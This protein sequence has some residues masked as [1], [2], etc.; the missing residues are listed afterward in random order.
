VDGLGDIRR[1]YLTGDYANGM[2]TGVIGLLFVGNSIDGGYLAN[3]VKK[4]EK[5]MQRAI[6]YEV[7]T[8][9]EEKN[10]LNGRG[11]TEFLLL[12]QRE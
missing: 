12:W 3:L 7:H 4:A 9:E 6:T 5:L 1:V 11:D 2:D 8:V 10:F